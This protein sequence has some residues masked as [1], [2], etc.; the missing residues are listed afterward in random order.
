VRG[1]EIRLYTSLL[2]MNQ[3]LAFKHEKSKRFLKEPVR[4][5]FSGRFFVETASR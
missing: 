2:Q 5:F 3:V 1:L 4:S